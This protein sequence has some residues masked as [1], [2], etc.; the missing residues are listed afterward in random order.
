MLNRNHSVVGHKTVFRYFLGIMPMTLLLLGV[1]GLTSVVE[2]QQL[3]SSHISE[4]KL[5][6][7]RPFVIRETYQQRALPDES[8]RQRGI[9]GLDMQINPSQYPLV[10]A[11]LHGTPA[12]HQGIIP[13]DV[14]VAI[15]GTSAMGKELEEVDAMISDIP[16]EKV[17]FTLLRGTR[18]LQVP[19]TVVSLGQVSKALQSSYAFLL[20]KK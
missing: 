20:N 12:Q 1:F 2:A 17:H 19:L 13:G 6:T 10:K 4:P 3:A 14:I 7:S 18:L 5:D 11:V 15:N 16:G 8:S 9:I